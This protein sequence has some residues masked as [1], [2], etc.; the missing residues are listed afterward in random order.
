AAVLNDLLAFDPGNEAERLRR[1]EQS[2]ERQF[3]RAIHELV[4]FRRTGHAPNPPAS[5]KRQASGGPEPSDPA[6]AADTGAPPAASPDGHTDEP[7]PGATTST[8]A[9]VGRPAQDPEETPGL[10][11]TPAL[12]G[13]TAA[14]PLPEVEAVREAHAACEG[15][16]TG[17]VH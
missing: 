15:N 11:E 9:L 12:D 2:R 8:D 17:E 6:P 10:S 16:A 14:P 4:T 3:S 13:G 5:R 7:I 1:Y